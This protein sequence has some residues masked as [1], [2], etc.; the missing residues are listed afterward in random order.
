MSNLDKFDPELLDDEQEFEEDEDAVR[1]AEAEMQARDKREGRE[2]V[3]SLPK[4]PRDVSD[5][6]EEEEEREGDGKKQTSLFSFFKRKP[7]K[8]EQCKS[9]EPESASLSVSVLKAQADA[10]AQ[11]PKLA[12]R[13]KAG[14]EPGSLVWAKMQGYPWWPAIVCEHPSQGE[15]ERG[16]GTSVEVHV[17]FLGEEHRSWIAASLLKQ[18]DEEVDK[19]GGAKEKAWLKGMEEAEDAVALTNEERLALLIVDQDEDEEEALADDEQSQ[20]EEKPAKRRREKSKSPL[21][22]RRRIVRPA[23]SD[24]DT[25]SEEERFEVEAILD[26]KKEGGQS[27]YLIKWKGFEKEEDNTWEP[28]ENI[29]CKEKLVQFK[30]EATEENAGTLGKLSKD[31][32]PKEVELSNEESKDKS[33]AAC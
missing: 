23:D 13:Q 25:D 3:L 6:E 17:K 9:E 7:K 29:D 2:K 1:A 12:R 18:W 30:K 15:V 16:S 31:L 27:L 11:R 21:H 8:T 20:E 10:E 33:A 28:E 5:S 26:S 4:K 22:K 14:R 24:S 19:S 32:N